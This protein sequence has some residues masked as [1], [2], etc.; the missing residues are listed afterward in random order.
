[1]AL[2]YQQALNQA[3]VIQVQQALAEDIGDQDVTA[4]LIDAQQCSQAQIISREPGLLCG[5]AW[6]DEVFTQLG[7]VHLDWHVA[8]GQSV[9]Q[10]QVLVT[11]TGNSRQLLTG[12]R[13]ALNF[14]QTLMGTAKT[15][16]DYLAQ[17]PPGYWLLDT[18]KTL[19]GLRLAQKYAVQLAGGQNHRL[20]LYDQYLIKENH[21]AACGSLA[22]AVA[23]ARKN[24]PELKVEV[25][26]E[27]LEQLD[28]ALASQADFIML[29]NFSPAMLSQAWQRHFGPGQLEI[30]G[31]IELADLAQLPK[32]QQ[33]VRVSV[34]ALTKHLRA[35]DLSMRLLPSSH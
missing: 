30:S 2:H 35:H 15:T 26:V 16:Q 7:Q 29:D 24:H 9:D 10:D 32:P 8:E 20:A 27:T 33:P 1:M 4:S 18:R 19:P 25:E 14:L 12:E 21:I 11:L 3:R 17:L 34:G 13:T 23:Q 28:Q 22:L 5:R 6:V 31:G